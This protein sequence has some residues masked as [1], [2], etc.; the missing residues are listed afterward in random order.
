MSFQ[1][2]KR[3]KD[4]ISKLVNEAE[5][6]GGGGDNKNKYGDDRVWKPTVDKVGNGYAEFRFLPA[7]EGEDLQLPLSS[8]QHPAL[9]TVP[10][11]QLTTKQNKAP[12]FAPS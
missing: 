8:H 5:K 1:N 11:H 10:L 9:L 6:V 7:P 12:A 3:N 4:L 2:L